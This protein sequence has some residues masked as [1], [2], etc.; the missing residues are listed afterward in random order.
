[1]NKFIYLT[2]YDE[3]KQSWM[4]CDEVCVNLNNVTYIKEEKG[5]HGDFKRTIIYFTSDTMVIVSE[6]LADIEKKVRGLEWMD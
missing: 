3:S 4:D 2:A 5:R 6:T 1:M